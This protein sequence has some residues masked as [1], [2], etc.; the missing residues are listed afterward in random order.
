[1]A[2]FID[3][4][5]NRTRLHS[6]LGYRPPEEFE[7]VAASGLPPGAAAMQFFRPTEDFNLER[8]I[9]GTEREKPQKHKCANTKLSHR[10]GSPQL[11]E[12]GLCETRKPHIGIPRL[13]QQ[14]L[15]TDLHLAIRVCRRSGYFGQHLHHV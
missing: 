15:S 5:Y 11:S 2:T 4:Y 13:P 3:Q 9:D 14:Y 1:M 6:A 12:V 10:R 7:R 8:G